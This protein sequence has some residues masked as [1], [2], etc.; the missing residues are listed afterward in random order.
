MLSWTIFQPICCLLTKMLSSKCA[1]QST[2]FS[3]IWM[4]WNR[5]WGRWEKLEE[6]AEK[7]QPVHIL[8]YI[9]MIILVILY[10]LGLMVTNWLDTHIISMCEKWLICT[11]KKV[12]MDS[13]S[14]PYKMKIVEDIISIT[15]LAYQTMNASIWNKL[16]ISLTKMFCFDIYK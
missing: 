11:Y 12:S 2:F 3:R 4:K 1:L 16:Q 5:N 8:M 13:W 6:S 14:N 15:R 10:K 9:L 7:M